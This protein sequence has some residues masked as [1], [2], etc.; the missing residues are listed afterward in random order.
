[1]KTAISVQID[2]RVAAAPRNVPDSETVGFD[3][4]LFEVLTDHGSTP[5]V[6]AAD[7]HGNIAS[8]STRDLC[9]DA[10]DGGFDRGFGLTTIAP[11]Q[12]R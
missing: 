11:I 9:D 1:L 5:P 7:S 2:D 8:D 3:E 10:W 6:L 4:R 12:K